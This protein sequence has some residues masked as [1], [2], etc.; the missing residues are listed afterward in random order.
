MPLADVEAA[1]LG[2]GRGMQPTEALH[3][4]LKTGKDLTFQLVSTSPYWKARSKVRQFVQDLAEH[5]S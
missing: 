5:L 3:V 2:S 4:P 1:Y